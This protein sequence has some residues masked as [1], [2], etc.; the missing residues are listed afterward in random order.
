MANEH[1]D[2]I[3]Y[4]LMTTDADAAQEFYG[5]LVGWAFDHS[6]SDGLDYRLFKKD[7]PEIGGL[8]PLTPEMQENGARPLWAGYIS[9]EDV[10][11]SAQAIEASGGD[12]LMAPRD[13]PGVGRLSMVTDPT[14]AP[15]YIM[16]DSSE[17]SSESFAHAEPREG[18]CAWNELVS[19]SPEV[20]KSFYGD[21]FG[22]VVA[23]SMDMGEMGLYE[24]WKN[25]GE[26]EFFFGAVMKKPDQMPVSLWS[27]YFR[28]PDIDEALNYV[29]DKGGQVVNGPMQIPGGEFV[30]QGLDPQGAMFS[31]IGKRDS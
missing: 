23:E 26:R 30:L 14:G 16:R 7:G 24:M 12:I 18:H 28:V 27:F 21:L 4:E 3:W 2:F 15:F 13:I 11:K 25:G 19:E 10:D 5:G 29:T 9:V 6:T 20:A 17:K 22:W 8:M 1:G 31:I